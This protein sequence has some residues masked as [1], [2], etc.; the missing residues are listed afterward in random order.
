MRKYLLFSGALLLLTLA[1]AVEAT[2]EDKVAGTSSNAA[3]DGMSKPK[4]KT[5][6]VKGEISAVDA[7]AKTITIK[8]KQGDTTLLWDGKILV[9][10]KGKTSADIKVGGKVTAFYKTDGETK[11]ITKITLQSGHEAGGGCPAG[12]HQCLDGHCRVTCPT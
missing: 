12:E 7:T 8:G 10:P 11:T 3:S 5:N 2:P 9:A 4:A 6:S 1:A